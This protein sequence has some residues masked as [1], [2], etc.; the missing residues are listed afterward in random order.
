MHHW[1]T[2]TAVSVSLGSRLTRHKS[3]EQS[4][5]RG[6][7]PGQQMQTALKRCPSASYPPSVQLHRTEVAQ[8][9]AQQAAQIH[10]SEI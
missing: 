8:V 2:E 3:A 5:S 9:N 1:V 10:W 6:A 7:H 4:I